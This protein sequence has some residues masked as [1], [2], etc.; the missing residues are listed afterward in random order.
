MY[1]SMK[2]IVT[3]TVRR[4]LREFT[5][6]LGI[7]ESGLAGRRKTL[8]EEY[9]RDSAQASADKQ[10]YLADW[11]SHDYDMLFE[12]FPRM[13]QGTTFVAIWSQFE[14][15]VLRLCRSD[16]QDE[17]PIGD[18]TWRERIRRIKNPEEMQGYFESR[19][20]KMPPEWAELLRIYHVRNQIAHENGR[21]LDPDYHDP[22]QA[23]KGPQKRSKEVDDYVTW[24]NS[25][26]KTGLSFED[27]TLVVAPEFCREVATLCE[28]C[29]TAL[30]NAV[31]ATS[32]ELSTEKLLWLINS[33]KVKGATPVPAPQGK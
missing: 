12:T 22:K 14:H 21:R 33:Q 6:Y 5:N 7:M 23:N 4:S 3:D 25:I 1:S 28:D 30:V 20:I 10:E 29:F 17:S 18:E 19:T 9:E 24:R 11:Y 15:A 27:D 31:P 2:L 32:E 13:L 16:I 26:G 8:D